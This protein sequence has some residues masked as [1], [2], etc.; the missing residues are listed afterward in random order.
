MVRWSV[1]WTI[2][3]SAGKSADNYL[4]TAQYSTDDQLAPGGDKGRSLGGALAGVE[5]PRDTI[6]LCEKRRV[7]HREAEPGSKPVQDTDQT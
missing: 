6:G 4:D 1:D 3:D 2:I 7:H 5:D